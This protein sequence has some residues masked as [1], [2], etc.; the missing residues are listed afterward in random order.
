[1]KVPCYYHVISYCEN[2][3]EWRI[4]T[5]GQ[6]DTPSFCCSI[7]LAEWITGVIENEMNSYCHVSPIE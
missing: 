2:K 5:H 7:H 3:A 6:G 1:M 4:T